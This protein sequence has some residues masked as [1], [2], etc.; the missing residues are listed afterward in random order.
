MSFVGKKSTGNE[1]KMKERTDENIKVAINDK[2]FE[3]MTK[4]NTVKEKVKS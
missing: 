1:F 3:L 4:N 2:I